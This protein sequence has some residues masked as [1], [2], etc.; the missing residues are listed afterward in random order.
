MRE[1]LAVGSALVVRRSCV[2]ADEKRDAKRQAREI[3]SGKSEEKR[4]KAIGRRRS[5]RERVARVEGKE[6]ER[7]EQKEINPP[8]IHDHERQ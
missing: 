8:C 1:G 3:Q 2:R 6:R 5:R 4:G 7:Q